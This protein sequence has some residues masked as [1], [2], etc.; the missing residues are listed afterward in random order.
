[1]DTGYI[2]QHPDWTSRLRW[3]S[4]RLIEPLA[5]VRRRQGEILG[6]ASGLRFD[7]ELDSRASILVE[8]AVTT[9][10][11]EGE[12]LD[13]DSVRSSVARRLGLPA[14]GLPPSS[15]EV[16]G[17]VEILID[18]FRNHA[19]PLTKNRLC[20]WHAALFPSGR[21]GLL[22]ITVG[23]WRQGE[24]PMRVISGPIGHEKTHFEAPP[25][26]TVS[27]EMRR[28]FEWF[29]A[30]DE[31]HDGILRAAI[32]HF[33]FVTVHPFE[34]GNGRLARAVSD[35]ALAR[36]EGTGVRLYSMSGRIRAERD[37]YYSI[38]E[39]TQKGDGDLTDWLR[40]FIG[41][42][43]R[44]IATSDEVIDFVRAKSQFWLNHRDT[45]LSPRQRKVVNRMLD[46]GPGGFE[47]GLTNRKYVSITR[48]SRATAQ[49]EIAE[50]LEKG[51]LVRR[52][53]A[54][55]ST[56]YDIHWEPS[57]RAP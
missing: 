25:S 42:L 38:L 7:L 46:A 51:V 40:W 35:M 26:A 11:I 39:R 34:D 32:A 54:G 4:E 53:G 20:G 14:A 50:L 55:R 22:P 56:S 43:E 29:A 1:M 31:P 33:L 2:W 21:S 37:A 30:S 9:S 17:L 12:L 5:E 36:D 19:E 6:K 41:C 24:A 8:E 28:F 52:P 10:A 13:R 48:T 47:G 23:D 27:G 45:V 44:A 49:R 57:R 15:R 16:D 3:D 18:A